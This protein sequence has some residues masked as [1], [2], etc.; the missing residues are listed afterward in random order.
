MCQDSVNSFWNSIKKSSDI[1]DLV[2]KELNKLNQ[3]KKKSK[4]AL[5]RFWLK[6][7]E[8]KYTKNSSNLLPSSEKPSDESSIDLLSSNET[9][10]TAPTTSV[11][12]EVS[13]NTIKEYHKPVQERL[14]KEILVLSS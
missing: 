3:I 13:T 12:Q 7:S 14:E 6:S 9:I 10:E 5:D 4:L 8:T 1:T 2:Q 11:L